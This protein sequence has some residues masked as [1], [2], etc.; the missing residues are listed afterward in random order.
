MAKP[1]SSALFLLVLLVV[2]DLA[3]MAFSNTTVKPAIPGSLQASVVIENRITVP[4]PVPVEVSCRSRNGEVVITPTTLQRMGRV[5]WGF[6]RSIWGHTR[7]SCDFRWGART[8]VFD[9]WVDRPLLDFWDMPRPC[10]H[11]VWYVMWDCLRE[12]E[13][14]NVQV[15][16][17]VVEHAWRIGG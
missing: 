1:V 9:V 3:T 13:S 11:C 4:G 5:G 17:E 6:H 7:F 16:E 2:M 15:G 10:T 8:Q 14:N 12:Y